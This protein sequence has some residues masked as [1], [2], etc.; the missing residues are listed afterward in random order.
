MN[1]T[2]KQLTE[3][4]AQINYAEKKLKGYLKEQA[5]LHIK[6]EEAYKKLEKEN[7]DVDKIAGVSFQAFIATLFNNRQEKLE[8]EELEAIEAKRY[9]DSVVYEFESVQ[10]EIDHLQAQVKSKSEVEVL[11]QNAI[12]EKRQDVLRKNPELLE[13]FETLET[14]K[15]MIESEVK[16]LIE[17]IN[18]SNIVKQKTK[19]ALN[20]LKDAKNLGIWDMMGGGLL[21]TMAKRDHMATAQTIINDL[22]HSLK[23]FS[24]ELSDV[25]MN[26]TGNIDIANYMGFADYF[27]DGFFMDMMVQDKI[28]GALN[29][30]SQL[31]RNVGETRLKL[32]SQLNTSEA[33]KTKLLEEMDEVIIR[34]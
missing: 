20:E 5:V 17:A 14:K 19:H 15:R 11:Y 13:R 2:L 22:N 33:E 10:H 18:A 21:V 1:D 27:F 32:E 12:N 30:L 7:R 16:E 8:K 23:S 25:N 26:M 31:E 3:T 28:N 24:K 29:K 34:A 4:L 6:K 9:Y